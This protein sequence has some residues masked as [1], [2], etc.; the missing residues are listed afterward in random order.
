MVPDKTDYS[1][2]DPLQFQTVE[3]YGLASL[4]HTVRVNGVA[5]SQQNI[6]YFNKVK[7]HSRLRHLLS[8]LATSV[9]ASERGFA[10]L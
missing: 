3:I 8:A 1:P 6:R 7:T 10:R 9:G 4:P 2:T 5:H